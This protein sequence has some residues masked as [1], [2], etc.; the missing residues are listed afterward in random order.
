MSQVL[1]ALDAHPFASVQY[2]FE[3]TTQPTVE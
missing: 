3:C 1:L 2:L